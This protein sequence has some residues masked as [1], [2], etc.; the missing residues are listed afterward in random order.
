MINA[1]C[2]WSAEGWRRCRVGET[3]I[4]TYPPHRLLIMSYKYLHFENTRLGGGGGVLFEV[5]GHIVTFEAERSDLRG[6]IM[7]LLS[8]TLVLCGVCQISDP[9]HLSTISHY[10][11]RLSVCQCLSRSQRSATVMAVSTEA[12]S[13]RQDVGHNIANLGLQSLQLK[14]IKACTQ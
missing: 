11:V 9:H 1:P 8:I 13:W 6:E 3:N 7:K 4:W 5:D 2:V 14:T 10:T 12:A